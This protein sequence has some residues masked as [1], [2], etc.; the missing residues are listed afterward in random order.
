MRIDGAADVEPVGI[1]EDV[2]VAVG[3]ADEKDDVVLRAQLEAAVDLAV[4]CSATRRV[5]Q[6]GRFG[7]ALRRRHGSSGSG[8]R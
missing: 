8:R 4:R 7:G 2:L 3:G 5:R 1:V 6:G